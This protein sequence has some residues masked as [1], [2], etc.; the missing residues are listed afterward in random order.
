VVSPEEGVLLAVCMSRV[1]CF[2]GVSV[3]LQAMQPEAEG[4]ISS[5][6]GQGAPIVSTQQTYF[7]PSPCA[8]SSKETNK[9]TAAQP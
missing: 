2:D 1:K 7:Q 6:T 8:S 3:R 9:L 5:I 4:V